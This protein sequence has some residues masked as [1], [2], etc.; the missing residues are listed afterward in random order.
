[1]TTTNNIDTSSRYDSIHELLKEIFHVQGKDGPR[2]DLLAGDAST[3]KY[4]RIN[5]PSNEKKI[6]C[7][8]QSDAKYR[9]IEAQHL[10]QKNDIPVPVIYSF[11]YEKNYILQED[12]GNQTLLSYLAKC[13][14]KEEFNIY[15][16]AINLCLKIHNIRPNENYKDFFAFNNSFDI[17]KLT[18]EVEHTNRYFVKEYLQVQNLKDF[19]KDHFEKLVCDLQ[20]K[21]MVLV[22]RDYHARNLMI[23]P[24][25]LLT[26]IDF[27][28]AR[29]GLPQY[30][31]VSLL[32]DNYYQ[33]DSVNKLKLIQHF[34]DH[35]NSNIKNDYSGME[36]FLYYY[37]L[38]AIQRTYKALGTYAYM[39]V[40]RKDMRYVKYIGLSFER[41]RS[42]MSKYNEFEHIRKNLS[43]AYYAS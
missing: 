23:K 29:L 35:L 12:L 27:Q 7:L 32:E 13:D 21:K 14:L 43:I 28:D 9:F 26:M 16:K 34:W 22:H 2:L 8:D 33:I 15:Q 30:D 24:T 42:F 19:L 40:E 18:F 10:F 36:E 6:L 41:L 20:R 17:P 37:D 11:S 39:A 31:I 5:L 3:R 4:F 38:M 1:M 25:G